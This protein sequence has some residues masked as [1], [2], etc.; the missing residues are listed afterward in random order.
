MSRIW[1]RHAQLEYYEAIERYA[2][3][4]GKLGERFI[5]GVEAALELMSKTPERFRRFDGDMR[6]VRVEDFPYAV[7]YRIAG[8]ELR[9]IAVMHL[10]RR[11][12]YW[13]D[14]IK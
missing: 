2:R 5:A 1:N 11:P 10:H 8:H 13:R 9:I 14:R 6:K 4:D 3:I 12:G 7:I